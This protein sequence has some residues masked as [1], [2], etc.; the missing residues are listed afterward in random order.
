M[1]ELTGLRL[2]VEEVTVIT[3][4]VIADLMCMVDTRSA[5][6]IT[7]TDVSLCVDT[8]VSG[9]LTNAISTTFVTCLT[10][11]FDVVIPLVPVTVQQTLWVVWSCWTVLTVVEGGAG[12]SFYVVK[13]KSAAV[14]I[15]EAEDKP[16]KEPICHSATLHR[17]I[18]SA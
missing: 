1:A 14:V 13:R 11:L 12:G 7:G 2:I 8:K 15:A 18:L 5:L 10:D 6:V 4:T 17:I 16:N 3:D 9:L